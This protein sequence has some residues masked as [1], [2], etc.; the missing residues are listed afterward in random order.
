MPCVYNLDVGD[1]Q[2][3]AIIRQSIG[4]IPSEYGL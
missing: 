4:W 1:G 2:W 3:V